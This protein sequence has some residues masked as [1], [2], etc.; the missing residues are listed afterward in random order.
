MKI[1]AIGEPIQRPIKHIPLDVKVIS[2]KDKVLIIYYY[3]CLEPVRLD[4]HGF[5]Q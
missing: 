5:S 3:E 1:L 2:A 4:L